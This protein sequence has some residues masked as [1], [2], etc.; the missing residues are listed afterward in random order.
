MPRMNAITERRMRTCRRE[1]LDRALI[2]NRRHVLYALR[3][4]EF[5]DSTVV[6]APLRLRIGFTGTIYADT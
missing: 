6:G 3:E 2:W 1:L 4:F 5:P